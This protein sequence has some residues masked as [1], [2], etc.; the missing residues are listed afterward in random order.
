[1]KKRFLSFILLFAFN[2]AFSDECNYDQH[3]GCQED[4]ECILIPPKTGKCFK[5]IDGKEKSISLPFESKHT[6]ICDQGNLTPSIN[7]HSYITTAYAL[8][9]KPG[10]VSKKEVIL[11]AGM[12]GKAIVYNKCHT[13]NDECGLGF[14][15]HVKILSDDGFMLLY[16]HMKNI[17]VKT[18]DTIVEGQVVGTMGASGRTGYNNPHLHVSM[19]YQWNHSLNFKY[20]KQVGYV[21]AS[22]PFKLKTCTEQCGKKCEQTDILSTELHCLRTYPDSSKLCT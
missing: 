12:S 21:P 19:H 20:W 14:G 5:K 4:S 6:I 10:S 9:L 17:V 2:A 22:V 1:M 11:K 3:K 13:E 7:S 18:G 15:N 8:D 16:A